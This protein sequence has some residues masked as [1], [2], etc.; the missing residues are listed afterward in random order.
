MSRAS[1]D[2]STSAASSLRTNAAL[3]ISLPAA[4]SGGVGVDGVPVRVGLFSGAFFL[5]SSQKGFA[6]VCLGARY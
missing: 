3:A 5:V 4:S 1:G 2:E 6:T